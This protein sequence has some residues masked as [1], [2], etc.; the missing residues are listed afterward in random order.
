MMLFFFPSWVVSRQQP[1][2]YQEGLLSFN[3]C[4]RAPPDDPML[5]SVKSRIVSRFSR[6]YESVRAIVK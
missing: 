5:R 4:M 3:G 2:F 6:F 1:L